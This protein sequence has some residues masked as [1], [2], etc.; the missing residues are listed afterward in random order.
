MVKMEEEFLEKNI[1]KG[2]RSG[3][4]SSRGGRAASKKAG[5]HDASH[6]G[7]RYLLKFNNGKKVYINCVETLGVSCAGSS[8]AGPAALGDP[9]DV[10]IP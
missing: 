7:K 10:R 4:C 3:Y 1:E 9:G 8:A 6:D 2:E 5:G